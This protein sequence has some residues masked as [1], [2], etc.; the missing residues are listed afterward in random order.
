MVRGNTDNSINCPFCEQPISE[1][2]EIKTS[3]GSTFTGGKCGCGAVYVFDR[4][5]HNLGDAYVDALAYACNNDWDKAWSLIPDEDYEVRE[6]SY[7][8]R[9]HR[10]KSIPK[11]GVIPT[12]LFILIK[13]PLT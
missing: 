4:G 5:G 12:Y 13:K 7:D 6:F 9:R 1:P 8:R 10:L 11:R 3:F 2:L